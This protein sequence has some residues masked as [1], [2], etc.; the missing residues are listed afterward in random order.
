M[1]I[2]LVTPRYRPDVGGVETHV[3]QLATHLAARR[4]IVDVLTHEP[5]GRTL[6]PDPP[7]DVNVRRFR[8]VPSPS[9][10]PMSP[11]LWRY[12]RRTSR[13]YDIVHAHNYHALPALA[14][15]V[16]ARQR[17]VFTPHY[18]GASAGRIRTLLHAPYRLVATRTVMAARSIICVSAAEE[19]LLLR[20][21]PA[22][23]GRVRVIPNGVDAQ[24]FAG[25]EP[26][27]SPGHLV[28][29]V[30]RIEP[31]KR[32]DRILDALAGLPEPYWLAVIGDG[33]ASS[34]PAR[35]GARTR[36][37]RPGTARGAGPTR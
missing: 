33:S 3:E 32:V 21:F 7:V 8:V 9:H 31:H 36:A 2:A 37:A 29:S 27:A 34:R 1:R 26:F 14:A 4:H 22:V 11:A 20:H 5:T 10:V 16:F 24:F 30:G 35:G 28:L 15:G 13:S 17:L 6:P 19:R 25:A 12:L 23:A 18:H